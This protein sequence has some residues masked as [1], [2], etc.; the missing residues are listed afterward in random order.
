[1]RC[2]RIASFV[3]AFSTLSMPLLVLGGISLVSNSPQPPLHE[4]SC[5]TIGAVVECIDSGFIMPPMIVT[6]IDGE[7]TDETFV[8]EDNG[9]YEEARG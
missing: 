2:T 3:R 8:F 5:F 9:G 1:M 6:N 7:G 4:M